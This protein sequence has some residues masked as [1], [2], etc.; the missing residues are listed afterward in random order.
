LTGKNPHDL[1]GSRS[2]VLQ[3]ISQEEIRRPRK[4]N[5]KIDKE[6]EAL[7]L[8][9]LDNNPDKRYP[10]AG[11]FAK[12]INNYLKHEPLNARHP[13]TI[14]YL[15]KRII[16]C[17]WQSKLLMVIALIGIVLLLTYATNSLIQYFI[18]RDIARKEP[19]HLTFVL[20]TSDDERQ[21]HIKF[22]PIIDYIEKKATRILKRPVYI[23]PDF[24]NT[25]EEG[26]NKLSEGKKIYFGRVGPASY[27]K[28]KERNSNIQLLVQE[29]KKGNKT[30]KGM[31]IVLKESDIYDLSDLKGKNFAFGDENSTI[32][33][34]LSQAELSKAG[35]HA[36]NLKN[37]EYLGS[38]EKAAKAVLDGK[39][40]ACAVKESTY[41][42]YKEYFRVIKDFDNVTKPWITCEDFDPN[43]ASKIQDILLELTLKDHPEILRESEISDFVQTSDKEYEFIRK[44]MK[45]VESTPYKKEE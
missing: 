10:S 30:F 14:Y 32:G 1:S 2:K 35:I 11:E 26:N 45:E 7:L 37:F 42:T 15:S 23:L 31:I 13:T 21:M 36:D 19:L 29:R 33:R 5:P 39:F 9:S 40:D 24:D 20:Y 25:Y 22:S 12:D 17:P 41:E 44:V 3:R 27:I 4:I 16:K 18:L 28:I 6:L 38:H 43:F 34:F 8:K